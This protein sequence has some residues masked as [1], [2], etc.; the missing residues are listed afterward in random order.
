M[1]G[2]G[3][4]PLLESI[5]TA[6]KEPKIFE[7]EVFGTKNATLKI[8]RFKDCSGRK[9]IFSP[10]FAT[11]VKDSSWTY[12]WDMGDGIGSSDQKLV[13]YTFKT[14]GKYLVKVFMTDEN[15]CV[16]R[17]QDT[18]NMEDE[19]LRAKFFADSLIKDCPPLHV[20][21]EDRSNL[22]LSSKNCQMGM[23]FRRWNGFSRKVS[24][25]IIL[26]IG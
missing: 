15:G 18:V 7:T 24:K 14:P 16:T 12:K 10:L 22:K 19:V 21:F 8:T 9:F 4:Y 25:Q 23:G 6:V 2:N 17:L 13:N 1:M 11:P 5:P 3:L 26:K 20:S